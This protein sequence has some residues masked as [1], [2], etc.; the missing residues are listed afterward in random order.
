MTPIT[1]PEVIAITGAALVVV[2][3]YLCVLA[4]ELRNAKRGLAEY[5]EDHW[6]LAKVSSDRLD[7]INHLTEAIGR[8]NQ[9]ISILFE[10][11]GEMSIKLNAHEAAEAKRQAQRVAASHAAAEKRRNRKDA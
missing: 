7:Q 3:G 11:L 6:N 8:R 4:D 1:A 5:A 10:W 2:S 9:E